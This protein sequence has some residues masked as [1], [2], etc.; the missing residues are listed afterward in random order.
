M[1]LK[2]LR[3][4][5]RTLATL[6]VTDAEVI[7]C[8]LTLHGGDLTDRNV[9]DTHVRLL[10]QG[11]TGSARRDRED[12]LRRIEE[13]LT[14]NLLPEAKGI[15]LF[16]RAGAEPFFLPMQFQVPLP[17]WVAVDT[18]PNI[19]HLIELKDTYHRYVVM[20][21]TEESV[22][23]LEVNLG[24]VTEE[25]WKERPELRKRVGREWTKNHYQNH[26]RDRT[27]KFIKEEIKVLGRLMSAGGY[28]HLILAG[29]PRITTQVSRRL[30]KHLTAKLIDTVPAS[31]EA[32]TVD[33]VEAT[34]AS[35]IREEE[36]ESRR[37]AEEVIRVVQAGG[38]A[39]VGTRPTFQA[40]EQRRVDAMVLVNGYKPDPG[41]QCGTCGRMEVETVK[42]AECRQCG[43]DE[44]RGFDVREEMVRL[45]E[46]AGCDIE[47]VE[48]GDLLTLYGGAGC[49]LRYRLPTEYV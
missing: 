38:L 17:N 31:G 49:L 34:I 26:R 48:E 11:T 45:A 28:A 5:I 32:Q 14:T 13:Y 16:S 44:F 3:K 24:T 35:F 10:K 18:T 2:S 12:A 1:E 15:A 43:A 21:S 23:I 8:Y 4:H 9:F 19:Y 20:I 41:W 30:P 25:L 39:A 46:Q 36:S 47:V 29:N 22:R 42:P 27:E 33:I 7:S 40:L 37:A 6:P